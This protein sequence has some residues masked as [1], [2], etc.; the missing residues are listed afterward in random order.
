MFFVQIRPSSTIYWGRI[1][2]PSGRP[3]SR[4][5]IWRTGSQRDSIWTPVK[6]TQR[7]RRVASTPDRQLKKYRGLRISRHISFVLK[8]FPAHPRLCYS[9][10]ARR[11]FLHSLISFAFI[12]FPCHGSQLDSVSPPNKKGT[13]ASPRKYATCHEEAANDD[14]LLFYHLK[15]VQKNNYSAL[16]NSMS[17]LLDNYPVVPSQQSSASV[18]PPGA[19]LLS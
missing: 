17:S 4:S 18:F 10:H 3:G 5:S 11:S 6:R 15:D 2:V 12:L 13:S 7:V 1:R 14:V 16:C 9:A 8:A 19:S